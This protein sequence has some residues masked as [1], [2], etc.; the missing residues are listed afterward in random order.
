MEM[1]TEMTRTILSLIRVKDE[2]F[3]LFTIADTLLGN[4]SA[5]IDKH[6]LYKNSN[7]GIFEHLEKRDVVEHINLLI[8]QKLVIRTNS[9][10]PVLKLGIQARKFF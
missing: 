3:G 8:Q 6:K 2:K 5:T 4:N 9:K 7:Y 10:Y 1:N